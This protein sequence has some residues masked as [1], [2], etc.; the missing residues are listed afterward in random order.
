MGEHSPIKIAGGGKEHSTAISP[1]RIL[2][3]VA[4]AF[5]IGM[6]P[7]MGCVKIHINNPCRGAIHRAP[8]AP[9]HL[10]LISIFILPSVPIPE[11]S[12]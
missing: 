11:M 3:T 8:I 12:C 10:G 1:V 2:R 7:R 5:V 6:I 4:A 9:Y